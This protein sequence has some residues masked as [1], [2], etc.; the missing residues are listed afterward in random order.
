MLLRLYSYLPW[1]TISALYY[2]LLYLLIIF[3]STRLE[4]INDDDDDNDDDMP[5]GQDNGPISQGE[6]FYKRSPNKKASIRWQDSARRQFQA[7]LRG[8][9][10]L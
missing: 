2:A 8:V 9:V 10:G 3:F 7:G 6:V 1:A 4:R 5:T